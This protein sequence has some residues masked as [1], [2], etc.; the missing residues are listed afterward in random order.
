MTMLDRSETVQRI[1]TNQLRMATLISD[2]M[3]SASILTADIEHQEA[4]TGVRDLKSPTY[5]SVARHLRA[6]RDN[7]LATV[8]SLEAAVG[9]AS[10]AKP[11]ALL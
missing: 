3:R 1:A 9:P 5:P 7:L 8:A 6:R 4:Q 2:L 11:T 10:S